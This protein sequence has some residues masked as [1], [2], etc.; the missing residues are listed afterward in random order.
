ME[1]VSYKN[2]SF[3]I[4]GKSKWIYAN[5]FKEKCTHSRHRIQTILLRGTFAVKSSECVLTLIDI[6][7]ITTLISTFSSSSVLKNAFPDGNFEISDSWLTSWWQ[8]SDSLMTAWHQLVSM[9]GIGW[10]VIKDDSLQ[11]AYIG[12]ARASRIAVWLH[13]VTVFWWHKESFYFD[14]NV[15]GAGVC[16]LSSSSLAVDPNKHNWLLGPFCLCWQCSF[17]FLVSKECLWLRKLIKGVQ[18]EK[19]I[20]TYHSKPVDQTLLLSTS[21]PFCSNFLFLFCPPEGHPPLW[22]VSSWQ[23]SNVSPADH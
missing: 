10:W 4:C 22:W 5:W 18:L 17:S 13:R 3:Y 9:L 14:N 20:L 2:I 23:K 19:K 7:K 1:N 15:C 11:T 8:L 12:L 21:K 16:H 6:L